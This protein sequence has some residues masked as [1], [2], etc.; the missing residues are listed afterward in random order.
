[1]GV[2]SELSEHRDQRSISWHIFYTSSYW[3]LGN[4]P[5]YI[6]FA[7]GWLQTY[8]HHLKSRGPLISG[9]H[10]KMMKQNDILFSS[11]EQG[12]TMQIQLKAKQNKNKLQYSK[13]VLYYGRKHCPHS[14][15]N[16]RLG[17]SKPSHA[18]SP[19]WVLL[20]AGRL[21]KGLTEAWEDPRS[22]HVY[23]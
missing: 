20:H 16:H 12:N 11:F 17:P 3:A 13:D 1:M 4:D 8:F 7:S 14:A 18:T 21:C 22:L 2:T 23:T 9:S 5:H 10:S 19:E 15:Q 6:K